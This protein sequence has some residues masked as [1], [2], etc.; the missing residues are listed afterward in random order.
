MKRTGVL[1]AHAQLGGM[2]FDYS[3]R[4]AARHFE[5]GLCIGELS[6]GKN[7][8][9]VLLWVSPGNQAFLRCLHGYGLCLWRLGRYREAASQFKRLLWLDPSDIHAARFVLDDITAELTW[10]ESGIEPEAGPELESE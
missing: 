2:E 3:P 8:D 9:G 4:Q 6:L 5:V 10:E 7:F 1:E